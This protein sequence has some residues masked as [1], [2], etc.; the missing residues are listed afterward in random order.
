MPQGCRCLSA[1][2]PGVLLVTEES[3]VPILTGKKPASNLVLT[4]GSPVTENYRFR[5]AAGSR[6][7][8]WLQ[9][10][11]QG[12]LLQKNLRDNGEVTRLNLEHQSTGLGDLP[13]D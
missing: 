11:L 10:N 8:C 13:R 7:W 5:S 12:Q 2:G 4:A 3:A 1:A 6:V 9:R